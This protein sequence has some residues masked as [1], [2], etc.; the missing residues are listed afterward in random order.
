ME[1]KTIRNNKPKLS[2]IVPVY[3]CENY[4][5][6]AIE[7]ILNQTFT[8]FELLI[9]DDGSKDKSK[10]IIDEYA[11]KDTRIIVLHNETNHGKI[12]T[13]NRLFKM[14]KGTYVTIHDADDWSEN[15]RFEKQIES[16]IHTKSVLVG[17][18]FR[19]IGKKKIILNSKSIKE[20]NINYHGPTIIFK[21]DIVEAVG[22]LY[23]SKFIVAEDIDFI[24]RVKEN[25]MTEYIDEVLYNYRWVSSSLTKNVK[26]Y[27]PERYAIYDLLDFL[28]NERA[29]SGVDSIMTGNC[30]IV[31]QFYNEAINKWKS[32]LDQI[33]ID[34]INRS[35]YFNFYQNAFLLSIKLVRSN[36][37]KLSNY[38]VFVFV[39]YKYLLR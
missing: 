19:S 31:D 17:C 36:I 4:V 12:N 30:K 22:G 39:I 37:F 11:L 8:D 2:V 21:K 33:Y 18:D 34:G 27:T 20:E 35:V 26:L 6:Q 3:N 10:E 32:K 5:A 14:C 1:D 16:L 15:I 13:V 7:S 24:S 29:I 25:Y 28:K 23:R 9:A 38:K